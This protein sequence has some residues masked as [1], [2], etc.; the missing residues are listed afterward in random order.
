[1][2]ASKLPS[3]NYR[4]LLYI[5]TDE[6]GKKIQKSFTAPTK[7]LA[8]QK[9]IEY[10][11]ENSSYSSDTF[12]DKAEEYLA[13]RSSILSVSYIKKWNSYMKYFKEHY[14]QFCAKP[15][16]MIENK[17]V[18]K[19]INDLA[20][21]K[22][23]KTVKNYYT[24]IHSA[25]HEFCPLKVRLPKIP[26]KIKA[27][28]SK[29]EIEAILDALE[30]NPLYVSVLL[31]S[32]CMMREGE[33][34]ALT[35]DDYDKES[36]TI[37]INKTMVLDEDNKWIVQEHT[38]NL[39]E[40]D[41]TIP[42]RVCDAIDR[43]G[44][45]DFDNPHTLYCRYRRIMDKLGYDYTFHTLRHFGAS[46]FHSLNIPMSYTQK[47]GGWVD[48]GTLLKVYQHTITEREREIDLLLNDNI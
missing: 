20:K 42:Q 18:Q 39:L 11:L 44:L 5:G 30:G 31:G 43:Y 35:D 3:G 2:K 27:I 37:S 7:K 40:R 38:K 25:I 16:H 1:M 10:Q 24:F 12:M 26:K 47:Y 21:T 9:A 29:A 34:V 8:E 32:Y 19:I 4:C 46:Y 14:P 33:I 45:P 15:V 6:N 22:S 13:L 17:D 41:I 28:P 36:R 48:S 23:P